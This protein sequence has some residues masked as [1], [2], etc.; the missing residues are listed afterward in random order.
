MTTLP[1][2]TVLTEQVRTCSD[3]HKAGQPLRKLLVLFKFRIRNF[4]ASSSV[5]I[6]IKSFLIYNRSRIFLA[7]SSVSGSGIS[8][9][10]SITLAKAATGQRLFTNFSHL[11]LKFGFDFSAFKVALRLVQTV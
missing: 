1:D 3:N 9:S 6:Q 4:L 8:H 10:G 11:L 2:L 5:R 7:F